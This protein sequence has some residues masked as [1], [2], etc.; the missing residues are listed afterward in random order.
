MLLQAGTAGIMR[1][2]IAELSP[3]WVQACRD[4]RQ[5]VGRAVTWAAAQGI[6]QF[7]D[8]GAGL[9]THRAVHET[10][11]E[12]IPGARVCYVDNDPTVVAH[13]RAL[14]TKLVGVDVAEADLS[15]P[16]SVLGHPGIGASIDWS[17]PVCV[18]LAMPVS[19][20]GP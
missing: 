12:I 2:R 3:D 8:L 15:A 19:A 11:R 20:S 7:L 18:L 5:F 13:A 16:A 17:E 6:R 1:G 10:A 4:N 9:P 14:L